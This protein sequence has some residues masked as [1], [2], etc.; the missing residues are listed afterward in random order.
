MRLVGRRPPLST[1]LS[2]RLCAGQQKSDDYETFVSDVKKAGLDAKIIRFRPPT[3]RITNQ[4]C[5]A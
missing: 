5:A 1:Q 2:F 4:S 3:W